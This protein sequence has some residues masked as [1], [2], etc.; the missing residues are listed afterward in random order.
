MSKIFTVENQWA[1]ALLPPS[2]LPT[3]SLPGGP[4]QTSKKRKQAAI[5]SVFE[6]VSVAGPN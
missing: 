5:C 4:Q 6:A 1:K 3:P 2:S